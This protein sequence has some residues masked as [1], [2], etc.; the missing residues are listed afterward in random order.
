MYSHGCPQI[1]HPVSRRKGYRRIGAN[2]NRP[3]AW[4]L[5]T[6][7]QK[8]HETVEAL[9]DALIEALSHINSLDEASA[10]QRRRAIS[11]LLLLILHRRPAEE[12]P[13][14][15]HLLGQHVR[16]ASDREEVEL[17]AQTMAEHLI[18]QGK[19]QGIEQG[20]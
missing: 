8:E 9:S 20:H 4:M 14:L 5:L 12:Q 16:Q 13:E 19:A 15:T 3:S 10:Q 6:V 1:R 2:E 7:L 18:E 17:M 11:Y